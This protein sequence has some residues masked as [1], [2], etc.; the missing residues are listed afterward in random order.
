[1]IILGGAMAERNKAIDKQSG[2]F[3][4]VYSPATGG[5]GIKN[6]TSWLGGDMQSTGEG[7]TATWN[8]FNR[9]ANTRTAEIYDIDS[10]ENWRN[11]T[12]GVRDRVK[13]M[14]KRLKDT[15]L[16]DFLTNSKREAMDKYLLQVMQMGAYDTSENWQEKFDDYIDKVLGGGGTIKGDTQVIDLLSTIATNTAAAGALRDDPDFWYMV[17]LYRGKG[18]SEKWKTQLETSINRGN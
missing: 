11:A 3:K 15:Q 8:F 6:W 2:K 14:V 17:E 16:S 13:Y 12:V 10:D 1:M 5:L 9:V 18:Q 7:A 4:P